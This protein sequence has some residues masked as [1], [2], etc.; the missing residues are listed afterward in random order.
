MYVKLSI[1]ER[2]KD[3][4][5]ERHLTLEQLAEQTGLS[6]S[7]LG[8]YET[9][10]FKDISPFAIA[11]LA[12]FYGVSSDYLMGLTET[13]NHPNTALHE[14]HLS[15]DM[16]DVLES[17]ILNNRLL[18]EIVTH[19]NFR[20]FL[21][22]A[23][24]Y[25]DR[26]ADMRI[27]DMNAILAAVRQRIIHDKDIDNNDLYVRTLEVAQVH[28][29]EYFEHI[30]AKDIGGILKDIRDK[31]KSDSTTADETSSYEKLQYALSGILNADGDEGDNIRTLLETLG[32][33]NST[34]TDM[35]LSSMIEVWKQSGL[36]KR[37]ISNRGKT[38]KNKP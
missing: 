21:V 5:I 16:I 37:T 26:I 13:K 38:N 10:D 3:L 15:D 14:L 25:I 36:F 4:R 33:D 1:P 11:E 29:D 23:E 35:D 28:E 12:T 34:I 17:G 6:K 19:E 30:F 20:R 7:A 8:K 24:I 32:Y 9:D 2:L 31:H 22:D 18:C 27:N